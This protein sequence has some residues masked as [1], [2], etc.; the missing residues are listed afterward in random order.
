PCTRLFRSSRLGGNKVNGAA[1]GVLAKKYTLGAFEYFYP[2]QIMGAVGGHRRKRQWDFIHIQAYRRV[3]PQGAFVKAYTP[4][5]ENWGILLAVGK[6][7]A[8]NRSGDFFQGNQ[9]LILELVRG[10]GCNGKTDE[11]GR[12]SCRVRV[13]IRG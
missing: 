5:K 11:I 13:S 2:L 8:W 9:F 12:A 3:H 4:Q 6:H 10:K 7:Q 1:G